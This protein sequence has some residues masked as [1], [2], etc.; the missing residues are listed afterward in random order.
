MTL[1]HPYQCG[2]THPHPPHIYQTRTG[3]TKACKGVPKPKKK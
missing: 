3:K 1:F 2:Q